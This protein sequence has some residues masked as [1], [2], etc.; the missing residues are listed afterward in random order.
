M[1]VFYVFPDIMLGDSV[2]W[3]GLRGSSRVREVPIS[4]IHEKHKNICYVYGF[5]CTINKNQLCSKPK[6]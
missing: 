2:G 4:F 5:Q 3:T 1:K 6:Q